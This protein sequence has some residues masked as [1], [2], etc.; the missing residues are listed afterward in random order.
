[1]KKIRILVFALLA[2]LTLI[3]PIA[4]C[5]HPSTEPNPEQP[6][7][8]KK[9]EGLSFSSL[10][11]VYNG[12]E[13]KIE[14]SGLLP[15]GALAEYSN[16]TAT[17]AG[18]YAASVTVSLEGYETLVL[19]AELIIEKADYDISQAS[20]NYNEAFIYDGT[21]KTI[22]ICN[23][24]DEISISKYKNNSAVNAGK[25]TASA[26]LSYDNINY[27]KPDI[28]D[29]TWVIEKANITTITFYGSVIE[30]DGKEHSLSFGGELPANATAKITYNGEEVS[31]IKEVGNYKVTLTVTAPNYNTYEKT[32]DLKIISIDELLYSIVFDG[33]LHFQNA[34]DKNKFYVSSSGQIKKVNDDIPQYFT[35]NGKSLY[36][37]TTKFFKKVIMSYDGKKSS[38]LTNI[39]GG[40]LS[41]DGTNLYFVINNALINKDKNGIYKLRLDGT[42]T[43][44]VRIVKD[45]AKYM[46]V[47]NGNIY[48][49]NLSDG[50]KLY[51]VSTSAND[52]DT[53]TKL[54]DEKTE[55]IIEE[56]NVL[57]FNS[58]YTKLGIG[59]ASAIRKYV[60][61]TGECVKLT[62]DSGKYLTKNGNYIYYINNDKITGELYG[63]GI[64]RIS[65]LMVEDNNGS[66]TKIISSDNNAYSSL[67]SYGNNL[68]YYKLNDKHFYSYNLNS[69]VET[70]LMKSFTV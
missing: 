55:F 20:W 50:K 29:C 32:V 35:T 47:S 8:L 10:T 45:T 12:E 62:T 7:D 25:Y 54:W 31:G 37:T 28:P 23:L 65:T 3:L 68:Y 19:K 33:K 67:T 5:S 16:N 15:E 42:D 26:E 39:S 48:Y 24:P 6:S 11:A 56:N 66:G 21:E 53:G 43:N 59:L 13:K 69:A 36:Y 58:T 51:S 46:V 40:E 34:L 17:N 44:P 14:L 9:F 2:A 22:S 27:N 57:Y 41:C 64:Y 38:E 4:A 70:D 18:K 52:I 30:Y 1:M 60:I 49:S 63:D 61:P